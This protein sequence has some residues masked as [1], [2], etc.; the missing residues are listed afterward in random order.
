MPSQ[1]NTSEFRRSDGP[2]EHNAATAWNAGD[3]GRGVTIAVVDSGVDTT[4]P[5]FAGRISPLSKDILDAGRPISGANDHGTQVALVAA[6]G[7]N[8]TG[9]LGIAYDATILAL[10][11]D[12]IGS[13]GAD[14]PNDAEAN[15][16]FSDSA[17][18]ASINYAASNGA[19]VINISLGGD[20]ATQQVQ[21][22]VAAAA[23]AGALV[24]VSAGNEGEAQPDVFARLLDQAAS[25]GVLVVGSIG[26]DGQISSFSNRA[27][28]QPDHFLVARGSK[29]CCSYKN[30]Q[31]YVDSE[32]FQYVIS[33]TSFSAP[34]VA[35]AAALLAQ[36]FPNLTGR[37]IG[38]ILLR[39]AF[40]VGAVGTDEIYGH[41]VLNIGRALQ[42]LGTTS[43]AGNGAFLA[44]GD[45]TGA[46]SPAM[47]D[48]LST[49]SLPAV[50]LDEYGRAFNADLGGTLR[51]APP[52]DRLRSALAGGEQ[53]N[54][55][56]ASETT[57]IAFTIDAS[58]R[59]GQT[60]PIGQ[61]RLGRKDGDRAK[62]LAAR[63]ATQLAPDLRL[64]FAYA[65][66]AG[67][68][69]AQVQGQARPAFLLAPEAA[70]DD[71]TI[72][73]SDAAFALRKTLGPWGV[74][75]SAETGQSIS[76]ATI[77]RQAEMTGHRLR[78]SVASYG[79]ALDR[80]FGDAEGSVG[81]SW[82]AEDRTL[83]GGRFHDAFGLTG[84][85]TVFLDA[86]G[87]WNI[88]PRWRLGGALRQGWTSARSGGLVASG[89]RLTSR[90]WSLDLSRQGVFALD[91]SLGLRLS[92]P[93]RVES[94]ALDLTLPVAYSYATLLPEYATRTLALSPQG[95]EVMAEL[96]WRGRLFTGDAAA[97]LFYRQDPGNYASLPAD[98]GLAVRWSRQ[99]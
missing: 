40:D 9:I 69:V 92:Q 62:V 49:A 39:S 96:A 25:G 56:F 98:K 31:I 65:Q 32:G 91:D 28:S 84:A 41:G 77:R 55:S 82:L 50:V 20:G 1:F 44:L 94:G 79:L 14:N 8:G 10:R 93:L 68:L 29:I 37:Q 80:R 6:A 63:V 83:L 16:G 71:G 97:S 15:C 30:G 54:L 53:R 5:E 23:N 33:G 34:Q 75:L 45:G 11:T 85:D 66:G 35:G 43:L 48:A 99:F 90:A 36:A 78:G 3:T 42:P 95:R 2:L 58:D 13:C 61:L 67:G 22:A 72:S 88:A 81:L 4:S 86:Q 18:A 26:D 38:D 57:A 24:V 27:G 60:A 47:G 89:S 74:T 12:S 73:Q 76:G 70:S 7:R 21:N 64:G 87:G 19:K 52:R 17:I 46:G 51:S 59:Q